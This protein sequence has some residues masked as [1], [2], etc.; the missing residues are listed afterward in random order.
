[1]VLFSGLLNKVNSQMELILWLFIY[2]N[3]ALL[4]HYLFAMK[5]AGILCGTAV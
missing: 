4:F 2:I 5:I 1:M 3:N